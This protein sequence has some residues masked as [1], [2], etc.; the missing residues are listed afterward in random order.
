M[1]RVEDYELT[2]LDVSEKISTEIMAK[3]MDDGYIKNP[4][5]D[6]K[7]K[8]GYIDS[9]FIEKKSTV[10][11]ELGNKSNMLYL[12]ISNTP[13]GRTKY[14]INSYPL[15]GCIVDSADTSKAVS[16]IS[17]KLEDLLS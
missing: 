14:A 6:N 13:Y 2:L 15:G 1:K 8:I 12:Q 5:F 17:S 4:L 9:F 7:A 16:I 11:I 3:L 10:V